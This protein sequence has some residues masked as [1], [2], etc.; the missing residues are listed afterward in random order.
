MKK[1]YI[2][3]GLVVALF[4]S[5]AQGQVSKAFTVERGAVAYV[6]TLT[7]H[8]GL[9]NAKTC[10][11]KAAEKDTSQKF[12]LAN[13]DVLSA[14]FHHAKGQG[15]TAGDSVT[16]ALSCSLQVSIDGA[17]WATA[18]GLPVYS[19]TA[20]ASS[21]KPLHYVYVAPGDS[22]VTL[23]VVSGARGKHIMYG[24]KWGRFIVSQTADLLDT[25]YFKGA[26]YRQYKPV[27]R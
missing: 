22:V 26:A 15:G 6:D 4:A 10:T 2:L 7:W 18:T 20:S 16:Y 14:M 23:G 9:S 1:L 25:C 12:D 21:T 11:L 13:I 19:V 8:L 24:S 5:G 17:N 27:I 3:S